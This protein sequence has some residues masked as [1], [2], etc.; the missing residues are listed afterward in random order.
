MTKQELEKKYEQIPLEIKKVNRW[1]CYK[2][3]KD[4]NTGE[5]RKIPI[6][7]MSGGYAKSNDPLTWSTFNVA[8]LGC[9]KFNLTGIGFMLGE[10]TKNC[11]NYFG[12][13]LDNHEDKVTGEKPMSPVEFKAFAQEFISTL[14]SYTEYSHSGEGIHIICKGRLPEGSNRKAGIAVEMY[15]KGRYFTMTGNVINNVPIYDKTEEVKPLWEKYLHTEPQV[16]APAPTPLQLGPSYIVNEKGSVTF[17]V[18][19]QVIDSS[20]AYLTDEELFEKIRNSQQGPDFISL[21]NGN[22]SNYANDHSAADMAFCKILAFWTNCDATQI[23]RI[24]RHSALMRAKWDQPRNSTCRQGITLSAGTYGSQTIEYAIST[25]RDVY[26][27]GKEKVVIAVEE[28]KKVVENNED[29]GIIASKT[30]L[31]KFDEK[32]DPVVDYKVKFFK[33]YSLTDTGNAE[34]FYDLFGKSFKYNKDNKSFMFWNGKT[35][36]TDNNGYVRKY[37]NKIID[38]LKIEIKGTEQKIETELKNGASEEEVKD[39][40][41]ILKAQQDNLKKVSNKGG[42]DAMISELQDL[43]DLPI[44][45]D[46]FDTQE[47][48]LNTESGVVDLKTGEITGYDP[49]L[50]LSKNTNVPVSFKEPKNW[51][52]FLHDILERP[53]EEETQELIDVVQMALGDTLTG[54]TNKDLLYIMYGNGSNGKSTFIETV[55]KVFGD[56]GTSMNSDLLLQNQNSSQSNEFALASL[57]GARLVTTSET[58]EGKKLDEIM[59]KKMTSGEQ[60]KAQFKYGQQFGFNPTFSPWM[61]TNNKP[62]IRA[63]DFGTWRRIYFIPFLNTFTGEKKDPNMPKKLAKEFPQ[64]LGW[65]IKGNV[66]FIKEYNGILP[67]P[68]CLEIA[69]TNYKQEMNVVSSFIKARCVDF[70]KYATPAAALYQDYKKWCIDNSEYLMP[71]SKFKVEVPNKGYELK[72]DPNYGWVYIG[73]KLNTDTKGHVFGG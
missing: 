58:A 18:K 57:L 10:D 59:I 36:K 24:Y 16:I 70:P 22:M 17:G 40:K 73:L 28:P 47:M 52:K 56:Y 15:D 11:V 41:A 51:L 72:K 46:A 20:K 14:N 4:E 33:Q 26:T 13:D 32:G 68:K 25:Q 60:M 49:N 65:I 45:N 5:N 30:D 1:V 64:I 66:K 12:I 67:K 3:I 6:N 34:R 31:V 53:S 23:D 37:A 21:Y 50:F 44:N 29:D 27:P 63:T 2:V 19:T 55:R 42:K 61:S 39:L 7:P 9:I 38:F 8:V 43:H 69:L 54:R 35:W 62:V 48:L 71:E